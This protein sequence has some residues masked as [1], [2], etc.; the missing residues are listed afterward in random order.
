MSVSNDCHQIHHQKVPDFEGML[1]TVCT[2]ISLKP[3]LEQGNV[4]DAIPLLLMLELMTKLSGLSPA[5]LDIDGQL[6][7]VFRILSGAWHQIT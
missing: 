3:K 2:Q 6:P 5:A 7:D 1:C 4:R